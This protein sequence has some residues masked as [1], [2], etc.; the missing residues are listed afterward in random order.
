MYFLIDPVGRD[1]E[2]KSYAQEIVSAYSGGQSVALIELIKTPANSAL[3][4]GHKALI[5]ADGTVL[6]K[7]QDELLWEKCLKTSAEIMSNGGF[8]YVSVKSGFE[9]VVQAFT[10][11]PTLLLIG[12]GHISKKIGDIA[13]TVGFRLWVVDD[14]PEYANSERFPDA[15]KTLVAGYKEGIEQLPVTSNTYI[16]IATRGHRLDDVALEA[17]ARSPASYVGL[18][19]S[20]RKVVLIYKELLRRGIDSK[21]LRSIH[22]PIG[23]NIGAQ[24]PEEIAISILAEILM[25]KLGGDGKPMLLS[26]DRLKSIKDSVAHGKRKKHKS[27]R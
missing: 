13:K 20:K 22:A 16:T 10:S 11:P 15:E 21:R 1:D 12:G 19:G 8:R 14:R 24:H 27:S 3:K 25:A 7:I 26:N 2:F 18:V 5:R 17:A 9:A 4:V 23:L 6:G